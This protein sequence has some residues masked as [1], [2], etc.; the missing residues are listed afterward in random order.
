MLTKNAVAAIAVLTL[1]GA[2]ALAQ[3]QGREAPPSP[4]APHHQM[5]EGTFL[6]VVAEGRTTAK[7]D[8]AIVSLGVQTD[9]P[10]AAQALRANSRQMDALIAALRRAGIAERDIQTANISVNPQYV[11]RENQ[12]PLLNGYQ[13]SNQV[14]VKVRNL[15]RMGE[16]LDAAIAAGGNTLNG[17]SFAH[18]DPDAQLDAARRD[19]IARARQRATL[20]AEAAG[21]QVGRIISITEGGVSAPPMPMPMLRM[22]RAVANDAIAA[23]VQ[24]GEVE[25]LV[26]VSVVFSL[27]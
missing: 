23:P 7:P 25:T 14:T 5:M 2:P 10:T 24:P 20:Y 19:A 18:Q 22:E 11:Y 4:P 6:S 8:M 26:S 27:N 15:T 3:G 13:A 17:V 21:L 9:G 12:P 16:T 1:S